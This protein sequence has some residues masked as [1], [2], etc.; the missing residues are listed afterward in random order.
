MKV[1]KLNHVAIAVR[2][3]EKQLGLF[4]GILGVPQ[5]E[6][7]DVPSQGVKV[8]FLELPN[9]R[10]ELIAPLDE[11]AKLNKYL[12]KRGE[13]LHHISL[14]VDD[15]SDAIDG[16]ADKGVEP[17][18]EMPRSGAEGK[19]VAFLHPKTTGSVLIELEE[20]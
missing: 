16:L 1:N 9:V 18:D 5:G 11:T 3:I 10:L 7:I 6:I 17:I 14:S 8:A 12:D 15:I 20:E 4:C 2:D 13:G 19:L